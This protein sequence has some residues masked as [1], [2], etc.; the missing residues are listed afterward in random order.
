MPQ[1]APGHASCRANN[2]TPTRVEDSILFQHQRPTASSHRN[3]IV[4]LSVNSRCGLRRNLLLRF[5][6]RLTPRLAPLVFLVRVRQRTDSGL[7]RTLCSS[8]RLPIRLPACARMRLF[9]FAVDALFGLRRR[10]HLLACQRSCPRLSPEPDPSAHRLLQ[11][12]ACAAT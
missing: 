3:L 1:L 4:R 7:H 11:L 5:F 10:L 2:Q 6:G 8:A 9:G 12:P